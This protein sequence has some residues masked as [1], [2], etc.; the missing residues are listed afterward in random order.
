MI[1]WL[2][3]D[4]QKVQVDIAA[5]YL[6]G[7]SVRAQSDPRDVDLVIVTVGEA[8]GASW[9]RAITYRDALTER[10][11]RVFSLPLSAM[12]VTRSEWKELDG[13]VVRERVSIF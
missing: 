4:M 5:A 8:D 10:F 9:H 3:Q 1:D 7:S 13:T 11:R 6:F 2:R 12:V